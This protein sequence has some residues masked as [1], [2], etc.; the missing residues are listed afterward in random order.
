MHLALRY[1]GGM[2]IAAVSKIVSEHVRVR[3]SQGTRSLLTWETCHWFG[4]LWV[5][6]VSLV[7]KQL[8]KTTSYRN[9]GLFS[10][11]GVDL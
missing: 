7:P 3:S 5:T 11:D 9:P 6:P 10:W 2:N 8:R 1:Q 4:M